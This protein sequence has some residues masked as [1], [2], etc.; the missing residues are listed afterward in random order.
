M[1][2]S[3][4][5]GFGFVELLVMIIVVGILASLAMRSMTST[6]DDARRITTDRE[7][8]ML[9]AAI[10]GDPNR[11]TDNARS[12]FGYVGDVGAFPP[13]LAALYTNPGY[14]T[15]NGPYIPAGY[16]QD[17]ISYRLDGWGQSYSYSGGLTITSSGGGTS[18]VKQ[19]ADASSDYLR[20]QFIGI[21]ADG[22]DSLP[23]NIMK[24]SV[25]VRVTI[26]NGAG[27]TLS[28]NYTPDAS[29]QF[30]LDSIPAGKHSLKVIYLPS[31]DTLDRY[32]TVLPRQQNDDPPI[33]KF[34][35]G[36]FG[37]SNCA[38]TLTLRPN[39]PGSVT[40]LT[41]CSS[42]NWQCVDESSADEATTMVQRA[43][44]SWRTDLYAFP[45]P[46]PGA[47]TPWKVTVYVRC[48]LEQTQ[49][50]AQP[51]IRING[52]DYV[53]ASYALTTTWT[54]YSHVWSTNPST[55]ASWTW[56]DINNLQA[57]LNLKGQ[58]AGKPA[59]CTQVWMVVEY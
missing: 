22:N 42:A 9:S 45:D 30:T 16:T 37:G 23:G 57:G 13:S 46:T 58:N 54:N 1:R 12:D 14:A 27:G 56:S 39:G 29:G 34:S 44:N 38:I 28:K 3:S 7:M 41:G 2:I 25:R 26:P 33:F 15:W 17:T 5:K 8:E 35:S 50:D 36:Y 4:E 52:T 48:K 51:L 43:A 19:I 59:Y 10:V 24:D 11:V 32:I 40:E 21:V 31:N 47:C 49:G 55:N 53:G 6:V 18:M 20:N